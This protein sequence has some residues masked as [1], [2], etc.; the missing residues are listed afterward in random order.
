MLYFYFLFYVNMEKYIK[1]NSY[2]FFYSAPSDY[3]IETFKP[4]TGP[5]YTFGQKSKHTIT[6]DRTETP[7]GNDCLKWL[8]KLNSLF[9]IFKFKNFCTAI[10]HE[11]SSYT[12]TRN[13][14][15]HQVSNCIDGLSLTTTVTQTQRVVC[16]GHFRA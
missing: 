9:F 7:A 14:G 4:S 10:K 11:N 3:K 16:T 2:S 8:K 13:D 6:Q 1:S 15:K 12:V 5:S